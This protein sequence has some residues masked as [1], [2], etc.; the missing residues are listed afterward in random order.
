MY[1]KSKRGMFYIPGTVVS[2]IDTSGELE[3]ILEHWG[4][5]DLLNLIASKEYMLSSVLEL[6]EMDAYESSA[7]NLLSILNVSTFIIR[8]S[9][10]GNEAEILYRIENR[11]YVKSL[12]IKASTA[13]GIEL[14]RTASCKGY[15]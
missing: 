12:L 15:L 3:K 7:E 10:D 11:D 1:P 2:K 8:D 13:S 9:G 6:L 5:V 14:S 4:R